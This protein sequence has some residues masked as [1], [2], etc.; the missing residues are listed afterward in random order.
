MTESLKQILKTKPSATQQVVQSTDPLVGTRLNDEYQILQLL[1]KG[2]MAQVYKARQISLDRTVA[3]KILTTEAPDMVARFIHEIKVH[4]LLKHVNIVEALDCVTDSRTGQTCFVMEYLDGATLQHLVR[5]SPGGFQSEEDIFF[6]TSQMAGALNYAHN[7]GVIHRDLKPANLV[8]VEYAGQLQLK[9][10][11]FGMARLQEQLQRFTKTGHIVGSP[12]Y[13]S[14]EQCL[15]KELDTRSDVYALGLVTYEMATGKAPYANAATLYD[16]MQSH[17]DPDKKPDP[18]AAKNP[19]LR[20][21]DRLY[22]IICIALQT[23][24]D[25]RFQTVKLFEEALKVWY[26]AVQK[27]LTQAEIDLIPIESG[28]APIAAIQEVDTSK[29]IDNLPALIKKSQSAAAMPPAEAIAATGMGPLASNFAKSSAAAG[30]DAGATKPGSGHSDGGAGEA[31]GATG[32]ASALG[33][34]RKEQAKET[35]PSVLVGVVPT[36]D[37]AQGSPFT[38]DAPAKPP[39]RIP[40]MVS[41]HHGGGWGVVDGQELYAIRQSEPIIGR[42]L[43][44]RY[45]VHELIGEGGMSVVYRAEDKETGKMVAVKSLK[46][47]DTELAERFSREINLHLE[48]KHPNIVKAIERIP[49]GSQTF[50]VMELLSGTVLEDYLEREFCVSPFNDI[51]SILAQICDA[52]EFAHDQD[53]I[54]RDLTPGN[55][56]LVDQ[57]GALRVKVLDF[58]LAQIQD[59][60]QRMTRT[61]I[62]VG[63]PAYMSPEHCLGKTLSCQ[64]DIYSLGVL[65]FEIISGELPFSADTDIAVVKAHCDMNLKA[66]PISKFRQDLPAI[67]ELEKVL[68]GAME[69][70]QSVRY[71]SIEEFRSG[72]NDWWIAAGGAVEESPF[73][74]RRRRRKRVRSVTGVPAASENT[75]VAGTSRSTTASPVKQNAEMGGDLS[76]LVDKH[77]QSQAETLTSRWRDN[78]RFDGQRRSQL[79]M[80]IITIVI[81]CVMGTF[82]FISLQNKP[83]ASNS[84]SNSGETENT[85]A[86][87]QQEISKPDPGTTQLE[88]PSNPVSTD[89]NSFAEPSVYPPVDSSALTSPSET[90]SPPPKKKGVKILGPGQFQSF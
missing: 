86:K 79:K 29:S 84:S 15:G 40:E 80:V 73:K 63:S 75:D 78:A 1:G 55:V 43:S 66:F 13:M 57:G 59:D 89:S 46:F 56:M 33:G 21:P 71:N 19:K 14:P 10:V 31:A 54:H 85:V 44:D 26:D 49:T 67:A 5:S 48:L 90:D 2:A 25:Q 61:G 62:L 6:V 41:T 30:S 28:G 37:A 39:W 18:I 58:G 32:L 17:C 68:A 24:P 4:S 82:V 70:D 50:F 36:A 69:K 88:Q 11:D 42:L 87:P 60:L 20:L 51:C 52:L 3:I 27:G 34:T 53:V 47:V 76:S 38:N 77:R 64:S 7:Q 22:Q 74:V 16:V 23:N 9:V 45:R 35:A 12:L 65:A 83:S 72:L 8:F 81:F